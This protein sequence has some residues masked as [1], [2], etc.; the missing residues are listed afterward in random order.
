M[1]FSEHTQGFY[2]CDKW[3]KDVMP[4]DCVKVDSNIET[5]I[6]ELIICGYTVTISGGSVSATPLV[7]AR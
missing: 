4:I 6:R 3:D 1:Y 2:V 5:Q 7:T